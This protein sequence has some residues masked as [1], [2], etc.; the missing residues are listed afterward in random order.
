M[1]KGTGSDGI[2]GLIAKK[3]VLLVAVIKKSG[4]S[5]EERLRL[6]QLGPAD[7]FYFF[8]GGRVDDQL[9]IEAQLRNFVPG[10]ESARVVVSLGETGAVHRILLVL[11]M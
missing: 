4:K 5:A 9:A 8:A 3:I 11:S 10:L 2:D 1:K 7:A 6:A